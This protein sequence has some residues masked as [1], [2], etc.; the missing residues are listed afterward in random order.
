[1]TP[2]EYFGRLVASDLR[3]ADL[4]GKTLRALTGPDDSF[5]LIIEDN[6]RGEDHEKVRTAYQR[7]VDLGMLREPLDV[8]PPPREIPTTVREMVRRGRHR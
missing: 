3:R 4:A 1:M 8:L 2:R 7:A 6:V 5:P